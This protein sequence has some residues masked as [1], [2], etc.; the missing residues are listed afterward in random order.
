MVN[1]CPKVQ[2]QGGEFLVA[3]LGALLNPFFGWEGS[4]TKRDRTENSWY[5]YSNLST[6]GPRSKSFAENP[7]G[8]AFCECVCD[9]AVNVSDDIL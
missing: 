3:Q 7:W 4:R 6:G 2:V 9:V 1:L 8:I 5:P